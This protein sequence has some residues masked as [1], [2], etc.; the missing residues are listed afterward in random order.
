MRRAWT[1]RREMVNILPAIDPLGSR[2]I[3]IVERASPFE[4]PEPHLR[5]RSLWV[6]SIKPENDHGEGATEK[7][8]RKEEAQSRQEQ[9]KIRR[10]GVALQGAIGKERPRL[11]IGGAPGAEAPGDRIERYRVSSAPKCV[12]DIDRR[13]GQGAWHSHKESA[14]RAPRRPPLL[15]ERL[16]HEIPS[17][18]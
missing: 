16:S 4:T 2:L 8:P 14:K 1:Y 15:F 12:V 7:Y 3:L 5:M 6:R 13:E 18:A 17:V 9:A 11:Q 10:I